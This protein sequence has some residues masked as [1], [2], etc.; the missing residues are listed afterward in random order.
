MEIGMRFLDELT[1]PGPNRTKRAVGLVALVGLV[2]SIAVHV[3]TFLGTDVAATMNPAVAIPLHVGLFPPFFA[4]VYALRAE[5]KGAD[6][7]ELMRHLRGMVPI[8]ARVLFLVAFYYA[9]V[10]FGLFMVRPGG[11]SVQQR[12]GETILTEH[13]RVV[14]KVTPEEAARHE[15]LVARGFSGHWVVFYL[16]PTLFFLARKEREA[17]GERRQMVR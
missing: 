13:G 2:A 11:A 4:T 14:R 12:Q 8:W 17:A 6:G 1:S 16:M 9:I 5:L 3:S 7:R 15:V 10:N